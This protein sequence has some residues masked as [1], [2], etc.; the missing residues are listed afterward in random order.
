MTNEWRP[1]PRGDAANR[2]LQSLVRITTYLK[3]GLHEIRFP[4]LAVLAYRDVAFGIL[5]IPFI[6]F[7]RIPGVYEKEATRVWRPRKGDTV[8][9]IGSFVGKYSIL[10]SRMADM[11]VAIEAHPGNFGLLGL[12]LRF[13]R[14]TAVRPIHAII[15]DHDGVGKLYESEHPSMHSVLPTETHKSVDVACFTLDSLLRKLGISHVDW[16]KIDVE[17]ADLQVLKGMQKTIRD[18][19]SLRILIELD[20]DE[21]G[22][23]KDIDGILGI[24]DT[25]DFET[26]PLDSDIHSHAMHILAVRQ[27]KRTGQHERIDPRNG[28]LGRAVR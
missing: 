7:L 5:P 14:S 18:N 3:K 6:G 13:T 28:I 8:V 26:I 10:A 19:Q 4:P 16:I 11:V 17:G 9:D 20:H 24:L 22:G 27:S 2:A 23:I 15:S 1:R 21:Q 12:N 25:N